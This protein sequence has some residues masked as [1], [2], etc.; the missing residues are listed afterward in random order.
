M[1]GGGGAQRASSG[2]VDKSM[3][4]CFQC[5]GYGHYSRDW[6]CPKNHPDTGVQTPPQQNQ[7]Q[8]QHYPTGW[9]NWRVNNQ[10][11]QLRE[12]RRKRA[13]MGIQSSLN[14]H[15]V[16]IHSVHA[17]HFYTISVINVWSFV[18]YLLI[19]FLFEYIFSSVFLCLVF[20]CFVFCSWDM[21]SLKFTPEI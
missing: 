19:W 15:R 6:E 11:E 16:D 4:R 10:L 17:V 3:V 9:S 2:P 18:L 1:G 21:N 14:Q 5:G 12:A 20:F 8:I 7:L 13:D